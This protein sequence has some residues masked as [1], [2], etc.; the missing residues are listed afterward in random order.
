MDKTQSTSSVH[1]SRDLRTSK[2]GLKNNVPQ[3]LRLSD[4]L[5]A[6]TNASSL[7]H[8]TSSILEPHTSH[9]TPYSVPTTTA[10]TPATTNNSSTLS[11]DGKPGPSFLQTHTLNSMSSS[12][13]KTSNT[14]RAYAPEFGRLVKIVASYARIRRSESKLILQESK[15]FVRRD[16]VGYRHK[17]IKE[18]VTLRDGQVED[19]FVRRSARNNANLLLTA[20]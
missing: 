8:D 4:K 11:S 20:G 16:L 18:Q 17:E 3:S 15:A 12:V 13:T 2:G 5:A 6:T 10:R 7:R 1:P 14:L 19:R 9:N